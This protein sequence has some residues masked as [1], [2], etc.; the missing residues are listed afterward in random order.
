MP[1]TVAVHGP[2]FLTNEQAREIV[3]HAQVRAIVLK[4]GIDDTTP[5]DLALALVYRELVQHPRF[6]RFD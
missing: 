3:T 6:P 4:S 1:D 5:S 2:I